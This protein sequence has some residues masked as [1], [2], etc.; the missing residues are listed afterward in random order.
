MVSRRGATGLLCRF[1]R[2]APGTMVFACHREVTVRARKS[3]RTCCA[4]S[5][6][7]FAR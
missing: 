5:F 1:R 6:S 4:A 7:L 3:R 2:C